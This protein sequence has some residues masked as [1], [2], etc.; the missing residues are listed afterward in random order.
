MVLVLILLVEQIRV[1]KG[2][3]QCTRVMNYS[4]LEEQNSNFFI[5]F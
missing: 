4:L 3:V 1:F 2:A 5:Y